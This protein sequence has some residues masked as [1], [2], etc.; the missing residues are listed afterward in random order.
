MSSDGKI[1]K[2]QIRFTESEFEKIQKAYPVRGMLSDR[3]RKFLLEEELPKLPKKVRPRPH[4]E[5]LKLASEISRCG[6]NLNQI[7][8]ACN[9]ISK[10]GQRG[11]FLK[12]LGKLDEISTQIQELKK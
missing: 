8:R 11:D 2:I 5:T 4:P 10:A 3:V 6:N 7:A 12:I 9:E 1:K